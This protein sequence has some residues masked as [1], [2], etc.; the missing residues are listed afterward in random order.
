MFCHYFDIFVLQI[1]IIKKENCPI[2]RQTLAKIILTREAPESPQ[3]VKRFLAKQ[4]NVKQ[5]HGIVHIDDPALSDIVKRLDWECNSCNIDFS[6]HIIGLFNTGQSA[7][8]Y[9][10]DHLYVWKLQVKFIF[11]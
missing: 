8:K 2:C 10:L 7:F 11:N 1:F 5:F 3:E 4:I 6:K 9:V